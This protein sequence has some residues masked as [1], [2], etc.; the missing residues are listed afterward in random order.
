MPYGL[1]SALCKGDKNEALEIFAVYRSAQ[2]LIII[3]ML[4]HSNSR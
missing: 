3:S 2:H 4:N 1:I